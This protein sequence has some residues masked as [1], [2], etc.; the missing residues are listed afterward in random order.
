[1]TPKFQADADLKGA[2]ARAIRRRI[3]EIDFRTAT[4]A[5]LEGVPD[6]QVLARAAS[7]D[8][9]LV[10]HDRKTMPIHFAEF[11]QNQTSP[12]VLILSKKVSIAVAIDEIVLIWAASSADEYT[13]LIQR[14]PL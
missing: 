8:R 10:T 6:D 4:E 5:D 9:I 12:G 13:N 1:M 2:I 3:P 11:I 14:I 7:E